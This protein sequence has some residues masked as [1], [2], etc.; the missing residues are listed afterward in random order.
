MALTA[1]ERDVIRQLTE[2]MK[3]IGYRFEE[4]ETAVR[5]IRPDGTLAV[6]A[7]KAVQNVAREAVAGDQPE[8]DRR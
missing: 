8:T 4:S 3:T 6:H 7:R 2:H 5:V 1:K